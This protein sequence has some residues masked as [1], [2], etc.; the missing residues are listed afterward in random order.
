MSYD[1]WLSDPTPMEEIEKNFYVL[2]ELKNEEILRKLMNSSIEDSPH[3][4]MG[5]IQVTYNGQEIFGQD[6]FSLINHVW[7]TYENLLIET[8]E[9]GYANL[10]HPEGDITAISVQTNKKDPTLL[11]ISVLPDDLESRKDFSL[12]K[13]PFL[14][15]MYDGFVAYYKAYAS[16]CE[17]EEIKQNLIDHLE[18]I[19]KRLL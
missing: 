16:Y 10:S 9:K 12:P 1:T 11:E 19:Q 4:F 18:I 8:H 7:A 13:H 17:N 15:A 5:F 6:I 14:Q 2:E 3:L